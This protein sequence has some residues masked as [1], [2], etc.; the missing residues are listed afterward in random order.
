[1]DIEIKLCFID[2]II[3]DY[4]IVRGF[5]FLKAL[6]MIIGFGVLLEFKKYFGVIF[7]FL[8]GF[9][10]SR[11]V[12][13]FFF[14]VLFLYKVFTFKFFFDDWN[15]FDFLLGRLRLKAFTDFFWI[16]DLKLRGDFWEI[17]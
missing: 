12:W 16:T 7:F 10:L 15:K 13:V 1:M 17:F 5:W 4:L 8:L 9:F 2:L 6:W 11:R 14:I 3:I